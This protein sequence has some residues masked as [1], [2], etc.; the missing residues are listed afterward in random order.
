MASASSCWR[1][2]DLPALAFSSS[3]TDELAA[4]RRRTFAMTCSDAVRRSRSCSSESSMSLV[5]ATGASF[6]VGDRPLLPGAGCC[7]HLIKPV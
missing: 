1:S 7:K 2:T 3:A 6:G 4:C 5:T